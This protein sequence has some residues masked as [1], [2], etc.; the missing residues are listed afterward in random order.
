MA[1]THDYVGET[2]FVVFETATPSLANG[3]LDTIYQFPYICKDFW[4]RYGTIE[5][6]LSKSC[7]LTSQWHKIHPIG[8]YRSILSNGTHDLLEPI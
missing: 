5:L 2:D 6:D 4:N 7:G 8:L 3:K 1:L